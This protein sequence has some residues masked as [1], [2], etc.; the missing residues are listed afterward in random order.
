MDTSISEERKS[1]LQHKGSLKSRTDGKT[2]QLP[3]LKIWE[4]RMWGKRRKRET[5]GMKPVPVL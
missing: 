5:Q 2:V 4:V 3:Y 1:K